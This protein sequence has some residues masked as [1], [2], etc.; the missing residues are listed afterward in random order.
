MPKSVF[1]SYCHKQGDWVWDRLVPCLRAGG[2]DVR[3]DR[4]RFE[5]GKAVV[6]QMDTVQDKAKMTVLVLS[7]DYLGSP[8]C[9]HEMERAIQRDPNFNRGIVIPVKRTN[10]I[11]PTQINRPDPLYVD[12]QDDSNAGPWD[13]LLQS[14]GADLGAPAPHW[15]GA[16]HQT[17]RFLQRRNSVNLVVQKKPRKPK[18]NE[19][20]QEVKNRIGGL[21]ELDL[22]SGGVVSRK[23][24]VEEILRI[25]GASVTVHD[26]PNDLVDLHRVLSR[27]RSVLHLAMI[28][29]DYVR[30]RPDY[31]VNL[32]GALRHLMT[33]PRKLVL[34]IQSRESLANLLPAGH[35]LTPTDVT[36][37]TVELNGLP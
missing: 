28:N 27:R 10:C 16:L 2:A 25:G 11:L 9:I 35:P 37:K 7:P 23:A 26:E 34:L 13:L 18:W 12:L 6:G 33:N 31:D 3:V 1:I 32:F 15:L 4:E 5:A 20:I 21:G 30:F 24:L 8:Y 22:E 17:C 19:L 36:V 29:F 14:C